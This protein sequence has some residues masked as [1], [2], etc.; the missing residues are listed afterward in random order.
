MGMPISL[1]RRGR[2]AETPDSELAWQEALRILRNADAVFSTYR[3]DSWISRLER[4]E[5][6]LVDG[7]AE[8]A[9]VFDIADQARIQTAGAFD[10]WRPDLEGR[11]RIDPSGIV[12]GWAI[13][14]ATKSFDHLEETDV[15]L[16]AGGDMTC[17]TRVPGSLG[18]NIGIESP[19]ATSEIVAVVPVKNGAVATS[20]TAH[21]GNHITDPRST[22]S[23]AYFA[24]IT[25]I[26]D[27][28]T[29]VDIE[30]T[31]AFVM[32]PSAITWLEGRSRTGVTV[33]TDGETRI[34]GGPR[35]R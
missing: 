11:I 32:G 34:F 3:E 12:K 6:D 16:S 13:E 4:G 18:W 23:P 1:A 25:V 28:L 31:A 2:H 8:V 35:F 27:D 26:G 10:I 24:S 22:Q 7:P 14:R 15:C 29:W 9:E 5:V 19:A 21:R 20:G 33:R 30:A 17:R